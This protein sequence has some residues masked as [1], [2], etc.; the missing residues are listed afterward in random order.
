[1]RG[2]LDERLASF[3]LP[4]EKSK[5]LELA[6]K[7]EDW[8]YSEEGEDASKSAYVERLDALHALGDPVTLR[9]REWEAHEP[10]LR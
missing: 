6:Q 8:L 3:V 2:K 1:M 5:I 10:L 9:Y 4:D 7:A